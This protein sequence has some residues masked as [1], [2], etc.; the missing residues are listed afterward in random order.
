MC[1]V[2]Q[3]QNIHTYMGECTLTH[4]SIH[5]HTHNLGGKGD[6]IIRTQGQAKRKQQLGLE[7]ERKQ[8]VPGF[9]VLCYPQSPLSFP[10]QKQSFAHAEIYRD[11]SKTDQNSSYLLDLGQTRISKAQAKLC[12]FPFSHDLVFRRICYRPTFFFSPR[13]IV[14]CLSVKATRG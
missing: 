7:G 2:K 9:P 4:I 5:T 10:N 1:L 14:S 3:Y 13:K 11:T 6:Q 12:K 8:A